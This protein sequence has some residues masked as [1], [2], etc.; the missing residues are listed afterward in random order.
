MLRSAPLR[1]RDIGIYL[2]IKTNSAANIEAKYESDS[3]RRRIVNGSSDDTTN[4]PGDVPIPTTE[5][6]IQLPLF[7]RS[8]EGKRSY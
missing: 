4:E 2:S 6:A 7:T 8:S 3:S 1:R 5:E